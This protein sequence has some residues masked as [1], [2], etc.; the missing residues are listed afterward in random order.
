MGS[1]SRIFADTG[2]PSGEKDTPRSST[3]RRPSHLP[4]WTC[5]GLSRSYMAR[6]RSFISAVTR[7]FISVWRSVGEP[8]ARCMTEKQMIVIPKKRGIMKRKRLAT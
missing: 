3:S 5:S 6:R 2:L 4:Y 7:G 8:G 1:R